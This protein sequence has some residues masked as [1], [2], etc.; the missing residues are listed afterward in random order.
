MI[1]DQDIK[2]LP[3][4]I[5]QMELK[6]QEI[7]A[8]IELLKTQQ[9]A[10]QEELQQY[11]QDTEEPTPEHAALLDA[12]LELA[13]EIVSLSMQQV[14]EQKELDNLRATATKAFEKEDDI[15][16]ND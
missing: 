3:E 6:I 14:A 2:T 4:L 15:N 10:V 9:A 5:E 11:P 1:Y 13:R 8:K 12:E 7:V 16:A